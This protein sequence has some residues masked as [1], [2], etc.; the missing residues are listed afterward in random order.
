MGVTYSQQLA[1]SGG[2]APITFSVAAGSLPAGLTLSGAGLLSGTPTA[3]GTSNVTIGATASNCTAQRAYQLDVLQTV[4]ATPT[5]FLL[6]LA[7]LLATASWMAMRQRP[8]ASGRVGGAVPSRE[9]AW[10]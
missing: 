9:G 8:A 1:V 3:A 6:L 4:P 10:R 2:A 5:I 7:M